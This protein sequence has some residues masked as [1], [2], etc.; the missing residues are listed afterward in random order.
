[1][2][3]S[4]PNSLPL[5]S[6]A[7]ASGAGER[8]VWSLDSTWSWAPWITLVFALLVVLWVALIYARERPAGR[9]WRLLLAGLRLATIALV[10]AMIAEVTLSLRRTG[11]P[12]VVVLVD[13]SASMGIADRYDNAKLGASLADRV[14]QAGFEE[15]T[16][17][18]LAKAILLAGKQGLLSTIAHDYQLK[19]YF[20]SDAATAQSGTPGELHEVIKNRE[21]TG[22]SSRLGAGLE[23]VLSDLRGTPPAAVILLSDGIN[24]DGETLADAARMLAAKEFRC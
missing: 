2:S 24:T 1:M 18:S 15:L 11:L 10:V 9:R 17:L 14:K 6:V 21:P 8:T 7:T 5:S 19:L 12:T 16:R 22:G 3:L 23:Q 13:D 20:V 4:L